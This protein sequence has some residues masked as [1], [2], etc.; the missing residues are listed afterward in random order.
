[1]LKPG[2]LVEHY[3]V[4][5]DIGH[6][7]MSIVYLVIDENLDAKRALKELLYASDP[8]WRS[9]FH[10]EAKLA[11]S[12][13]H[14]SIVT[15]HDHFVHDD[16]P[17]IVLQYHPLGSARPLVGSGLASEQV[18]GL[19]TSVLEGLEAAEA[20]GIVHRDLKPDNLLRTK[21]GSI[22]IADFGIARAVL[23]PHLTP[24][25]R[26]EG[27]EYYVAPEVAQGREASV[28][29]DLYS[30]GVIAYEFFR[31]R[32]PFGRSVSQN[33]VLA[34]KTRENALPMRVV[35]PDLHIGVAN[36][37]DRLLSREPSKRYASASD[38]RRALE[39]AADVALGS[40]WR[41]RS[42]LPTGDESL[43][44]VEH[45][46]QVIPS[47]FVGV[48]QIREI[49]SLPRHALS[50]VASPMSLGVAGALVLAGIVR[51]EGWMLVIACLS[52]GILSALRFFDQ[53]AAYDSRG[54][55]FE[56]IKTVLRN[57]LGPVN[58]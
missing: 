49:V 7:G 18:I 22:R 34:R 56:R 15:I 44:T 38:A 10:N 33:E 35:V 17:Y 8:G 20:A 39:T 5:A 50:V 57:W 43:R 32:P 24:S 55:R 3:R 2:D 11:A 21:Q 13:D 9:R 16:V 58:D 30:V 26:L 51:R 52:F 29:S 45:P 54:L 25:G 19:L 48:G 47:R 1:V 41:Q 53:H 46:P 6:G 14:P 31:G 40:D 27:N 4:V 23:D 28:R 12:L 42:S 37:V 36:W